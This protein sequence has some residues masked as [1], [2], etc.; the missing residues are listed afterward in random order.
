MYLPP[1]LF[2]PS[3][4]LPLLWDS[5]L[6]PPPTGSLPGTQGASCPSVVSQHAVTPLGMKAF[7]TALQASRGRA[8]MGLGTASATATALA[9]CLAHVGT[10]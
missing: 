5:G 7:P 4:L 8:G 1:A 6:M 2:L 10:C 3:Q 9:H